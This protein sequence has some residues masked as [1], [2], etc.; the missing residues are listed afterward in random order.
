[1][2][3]SGKRALDV[4][5]DQIAALARSAMDEGVTVRK[6]I[7]AGGRVACAVARPFYHDETHRT[8]GAVVVIC[9]W[10]STSA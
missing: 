4:T 10:P 7:P 3:A 9:G 8:T 1:V 6:E 5:D 2:F